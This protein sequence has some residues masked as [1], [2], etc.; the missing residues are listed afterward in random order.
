MSQ[1]PM[2]NESNNNPVNTVCG[3]GG[4]IHDNC[5]YRRCPL[6]AV[7]RTRGA[8]AWPHSKII[9]SI[10]CGVTVKTCWRCVRLMQKNISNSEFSDVISHD[11]Y[12]IPDAV[13]C[14]YIVLGTVQC[15]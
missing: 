10:A 6:S 9:W 11:C 3:A 4:T 2:S 1:G 13:A 12:F 14:T 5:W 7:Q 15:S 8:C